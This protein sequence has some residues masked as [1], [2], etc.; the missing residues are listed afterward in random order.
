MS[1][2]SSLNKIIPNIIGSA[3]QVLNP[4]ILN[5]ISEENKLLIFYFHGLY[6]SLKQ[7]DLHH[8]DPQNNITVSQFSEFIEYFLNHK[9]HFI[10]PED[11]LKPLQPNHRYVMITF[12]DG[13]FNNMLAIDV[14]KKYKIPA[15]FFLS[16]YHI[17][18]GKS[19][20]WDIIYKYRYKQGYSLTNIRNEQQKLKK[21]K[22]NE[23]DAYI[24]KEFGSGAHNPW[25]DIDRPFTESEVK[26]IAQN[27]LVSI[28]NHTLHHAVLTNYKDEE[29]M[30]EINCCSEYI[31]DI[32]GIRPVA[33]AFPNGN[34]N[35][36]ILSIS[37]EIGLRIAFTTQQCG[38]NIPVNSDKIIP[39]NRF[40]ARSESIRKYGS[41]VRLGYS[42]ESLYMNLK[43]R[44]TSP[45]Q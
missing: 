10:K 28:G 35:E 32:T 19:Y 31:E 41:F 21:L 6:E 4:I 12:D 20:W 15:A 13:Y 9:Y 43:R 37:Q 44:I 36:N 29:I 17:K 5:F 40:M 26:S 22:W 11:L 34:F 38:N 3:G 27:N 16:A 1:I 42:S 45:L 7:K 18:G 30:K 24:E 8:A 33:I 14:L 25:S 39:L 23:I 2:K